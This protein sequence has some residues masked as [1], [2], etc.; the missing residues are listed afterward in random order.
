M[1]ELSTLSVQF[2]QVVNELRSVSMLNEYRL[3]VLFGTLLAVV[4]YDFVGWTV[5]GLK[6]LHC[7][8]ITL[9]SGYSSL[10]FTGNAQ[11]AIPSEHAVYSTVHG[12]TQR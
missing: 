9:G 8:S 5:R 12:C 3:Q 4:R 1:T 2:R 10:S 11:T 6:N 7:I